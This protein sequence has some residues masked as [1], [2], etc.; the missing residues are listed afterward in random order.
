MDDAIAQ[1]VQLFADISQQIYHVYYVQTDILET[2][3]PYPRLDAPCMFCDA[4][5]QQKYNSGTPKICHALQD[6]I[7]FHL[8]FFISFLEKK[9]ALKSYLYSFNIRHNKSPYNKS[10]YGEHTINYRANVLH[11]KEE[12]ILT[13]LI[14]LD[15]AAKD[16]P[17]ESNYILDKSSSKICLTYL[18]DGEI[19]AER[20]WSKQ[21]MLTPTEQE[22]IILASQNYS[23]REI[24][25]ILNDEVQTIGTIRKRIFEKLGVHGMPQAVIYCKVHGIITV[26]NVMELERKKR[27]KTSS[28]KYT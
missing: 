8:K 24:A 15:L 27:R 19:R 12:H 9:S 28:R 4:P 2:Y 13:L 18:R 7:V 3:S 11:V 5:C 26:D 17:L 20:N 23:N 1:Q 16:T 6:R 22:V 21:P 25:S 14:R 10:P